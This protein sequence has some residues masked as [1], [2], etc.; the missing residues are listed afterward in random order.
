LIA[1]GV[2]M[3]FMADMWGYWKEFPNR[4]RSVGWGV[5]VLVLITIGS[6]VLIMGTPG[7]VRLYRFDDEKVQDLQTIQ[8]QVV[9]YYQTKGSIP[10]SL[11]DLDDPLSEF[12]VPADP[13]GNGEA[14]SYQIKGPLDFALCA[15]FNAD[16]QLGS[17]YSGTDRSVPIAAP[18]MP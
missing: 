3:H 11:S 5:A 1:A 15:T 8:S 6:G 13:Q 9:N 4:A 14:Y 16:T 7:Q 17:P 18:A 12:T 2:L 10:S